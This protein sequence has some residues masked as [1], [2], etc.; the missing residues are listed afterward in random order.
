MSADVWKAVELA[1]KRVVRRMIR[2]DEREDISQEIFL[3]ILESLRTV[4]DHDR[5]EGWASRVA[6]NWVVNTFR[7]RARWR[8]L[9]VPNDDADVAVEGPDYETRERLALAYSAFEKLSTAQRRVL[10]QRWFDEVPAERM[11]IREACSPRTAKRRVARAQHRFEVLLKLS[12][13]PPRHRT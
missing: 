2:D 8:R 7:K 10:E 13:R 12:T 5:I 6:T 4:R 11:A 3:T 9:I 1:V